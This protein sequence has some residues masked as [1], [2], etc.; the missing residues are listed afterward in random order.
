MKQAQIETSAPWVASKRP[1]RAGLPKKPPYTNT[2]ILPA[3]LVPS[4]CGYDSSR[5]G[6]CVG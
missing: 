6:Y 2:V 1:K 3:S 4:I 5:R